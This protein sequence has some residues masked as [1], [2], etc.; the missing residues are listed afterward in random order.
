MPKHT[1][2]PEYKSKG[3]D[4]LGRAESIS[5]ASV[6]AETDMRSL[7]YV[8]ERFPAILQQRAKAQIALLHKMK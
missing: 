8:N 6:T 7:E 5:W 1:T 4:M 3:S 2:A